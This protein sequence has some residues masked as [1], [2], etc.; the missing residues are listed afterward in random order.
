[1]GVDNRFGVDPAISELMSVHP[2]LTDATTLAIARAL[3]VQTWM[4]YL[5]Y[6]S[7]APF[8]NIPP[9]GAGEGLSPHGGG[10]ESLAKRRGGYKR[11][12]PPVGLDLYIMS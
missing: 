1:M 8:T 2:E 12:N 3:G 5:L 10:W 9:T 7:T 6:P 4:L 11:Q